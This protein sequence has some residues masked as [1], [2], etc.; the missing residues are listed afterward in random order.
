MFDNLRDMDSGE[1]FVN[2]ITE[3]EQKTL[4]KKRRVLRFRSPIYLDI[5]DKRIEKF[6]EDDPLQAR[7]VEFLQQNTDADNPQKA[8]YLVRAFVRDADNREYR[9][10]VPK[11]LVN[12]IRNIQLKH[13]E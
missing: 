1:S 12:L 9:V 6:G 11:T 4:P 13:D 7:L 3:A 2:K 10:R 8:S 5:V